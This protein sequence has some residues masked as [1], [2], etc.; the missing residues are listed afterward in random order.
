MEISELLTRPHA[1]K[2]GSAA[3]YLEGFAS[4]MAAAGYAWLTIDGYL[5]SAIHF[6]GWVK[7]SG[8]DLATSNEE[9]IEAFAAHYCQCPGHRVQK[10]LSH[11]YVARV[12]RFAEYLRQ[13]GRHQGKCRLT[14]ENPF[15]PERSSGLASPASGPSSGDCR[16]ARTPDHKNAAGARQR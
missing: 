5:S 10:H 9:T 8:L 11:D 12:Q 2:A 7:A 6:G 14:D 16:T 13:Q 4:Q 15:A 1:M 3:P